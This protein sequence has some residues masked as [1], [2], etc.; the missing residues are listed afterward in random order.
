MEE[1]MSKYKLKNLKIKMKI[2][3]MRP[4]DMKHKMKNYHFS[5]IILIVMIILI[6]LF[7]IIMLLN[8]LI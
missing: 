8:I 5:K 7:F 4:K 1:I 3:L 2:I 6:I